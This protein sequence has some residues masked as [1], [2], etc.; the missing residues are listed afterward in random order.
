MPTI[1]RQDNSR[2]ITR[3]TIELRPWV[4]GLHTWLKA[5]SSGGA[6]RNRPP[7]STSSRRM[8]QQEPAAGLGDE[9]NE[10]LSYSSDSSSSARDPR[11]ITS[12]INASKARL[13]D[14][15][16][17][18]RLSPWR[19]YL[20][21]VVEDKIREYFEAQTDGSAAVM[22]TAEAHDGP[23][24]ENPDVGLKDMEGE[25]VDEAEQDLEAGL[26]QDHTSLA[27]EAVDQS[28]NISVIGENLS[29]S[30]AK[31]VTE[32]DQPLGAEG[33]SRQNVAESLFNAKPREK[34]DGKKKK[35]SK[36]SGLAQEVFNWLM[37]HGPLSSSKQTQDARYEH[38]SRSQSH[39]I[40]PE[41]SMKAG[42]GKDKQ[43]ELSVIDEAPPEHDDHVWNSPSQLQSSHPIRYGVHAVNTLQTSGAKSSLARDLTRW[44]LGSQKSSSTPARDRQGRHLSYATKHGRSMQRVEQLLR[45]G[46]E[47][48]RGLEAASHNVLGKKEKGKG[49]QTVIESTKVKIGKMVLRY[50]IGE[51]EKEIRNAKS[52]KWGEDGDERR[53]GRSMVRDGDF[54]QENNKRPMTEKRNPSVISSHH[55]PPPPPSAMSTTES[56]EGGPV[57][58]TGPFEKGERKKHRLPLPTDSESSQ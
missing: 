15:P 37:F 30:A 8:P 44:I 17:P 41:T 29:L 38:H 42:K 25:K 24:K 20:E 23:P 33:S 27:G 47:V 56:K 32:N 21:N 4:R 57:S 58:P 52:N 53:I 11:E 43:A 48:E 3:P 22:R 2:E 18:S 51:G 34:S 6:S 54:S 19:R 10:S 7:R 16:R 9:V 49:G 31:E 39:H 14:G 36:K 50:L 13:K 40:N 12:P 35:K 1:P 28:T 26:Q 46:L 5:S 45:Q 55:S